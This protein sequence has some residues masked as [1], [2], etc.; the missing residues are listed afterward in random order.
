MKKLKNFKESLLNEDVPA[1]NVGGG[2]IA[3]V[4]VGEDGEPGVKKK[5]TFN[6]LKKMLRRN[7][8]HD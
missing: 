3:G 5:K 8:K 1:N 2:D 7:L 6:V 4:G